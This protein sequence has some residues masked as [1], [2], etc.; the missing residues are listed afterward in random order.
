[1]NKSVFNQICIINR[2]RCRYRVTH[3]LVDRVMLTQFCLR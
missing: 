1:M 3:L 2:Y